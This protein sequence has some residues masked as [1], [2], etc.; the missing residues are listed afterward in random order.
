MHGAT[1]KITNV[2][3]HV[4]R[5]TSTVYYRVTFLKYVTSTSF[6]RQW[7]VTVPIR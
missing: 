7:K 4:S 2:T 6:S 3:E 1:I 5:H